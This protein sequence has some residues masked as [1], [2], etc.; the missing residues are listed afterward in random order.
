MTTGGD[1]TNRVKSFKFE[2]KSN[3][4][5]QLAQLKSVHKTGP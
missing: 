5:L 2:L 1:F 4:K 3:T